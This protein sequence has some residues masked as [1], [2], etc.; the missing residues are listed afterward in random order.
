MVGVVGA[1]HIRVRL[2]PD[3]ACFCTHALGGSGLLVVICLAYGTSD[4]RPS[5][6]CRACR[7]AAA[8]AR[9]AM[10]YPH[11]RCLCRVQGIARNWE[12]AGYPETGELVSKYLQVSRCPSLSERCFR[13]FA[14]SDTPPAFWRPCHPSRGPAPKSLL[15][16]PYAGCYKAG[17]PP[18]T[19]L[20]S[21]CAPC[22][23]PSKK[24]PAPTSLA[25][26]Q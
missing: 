1:G 13:Q 10:P 12:R 16:H 11:S 24:R 6:A 20:P 26:S 3:P 8:H 9:C 25:L 19:L 22:R 23:C 21:T 15:P 7:A 2:P 17:C 5:A 18:S 4:A 14:T